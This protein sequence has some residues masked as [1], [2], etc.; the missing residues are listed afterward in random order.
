[1]EAR[2]STRAVGIAVDSTGAVYVAGETFSSNFPTTAGQSFT[3]NYD[4]FVAKLDPDRFITSVC[5]ASWRLHCD[6][7]PA[8]TRWLARDLCR[9]PG[10]MQLELQRVRDGSN[11]YHRFPGD[12]GRIQ[13][14]APNIFNAFVT[15]V[16][17]DGSQ[18]LY[19]TYYA[20]GP[21]PT[22]DG[23]SS[24]AASI[25]V[26]GSGDAFISGTADVATLPNT[27]GVGGA[28]HGG[29]DCFV[30]EFNSSG[31]NLI[32]A[33]YLGGI[34]YDEGSGIALDPG[35]SSNCNSYVAGFTWS[36]D[37]PT[38]S[39]AFQTTF[40]GYE[41]AF[42]TKL[43]GT[44][45]VVYSTY[46]GDAGADGAEA[47]SVDSSGSAYVTGFT[48]FINFP[49]V[50]A[51]QGPSAP[52]FQLFKATDGATFNPAA[53]STLASGVLSISIDPVNPN[54]IYVGTNRS[55]VLKS[56]DGGASFSP[57]GLT[58]QPAGAIS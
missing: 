50:N 55:G 49:Q 3:G 1:M 42:V 37:F 39:G 25:A 26:D 53:P 40:G 32:F 56:T 43:N 29:A 15:S 13:T 23:T 8:G 57:T 27:V 51:L 11:H 31:T 2:L 36:T 4:A 30:A 28:Y 46:L 45:S 5:E 18:V 20:G 21:G 9:H 48:A 47:I 44:G 10:W 6:K 38:T 22:N 58:G 19:S 17:A 14:S 34:G 52:F 24:M 7:Q 54:T 41:D 33:R 12:D 35:C 16:S